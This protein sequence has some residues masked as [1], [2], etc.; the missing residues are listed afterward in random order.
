MA[1]SESITD[2]PSIGDENELWRRI[3][4]WW[5]VPDE[6]RGSF[7]PASAAFDDDRDG[8]MSVFLASVMAEIGRTPEHVL[9]GHDGY[10]LCGVAALIV[11][12]EGQI[13]VRHP[14]EVEPAH[15]EV[16]GYKS[17]GVRKRISRE[18]RWI[19]QPSP[20]T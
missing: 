1:E 4:H 16:V 12:R 20:K 19:I 2:D 14:T 18:A 13:I 5:I 9:I 6:N 8:P 3:P 17:G 15:A 7:R 11:R 10:G